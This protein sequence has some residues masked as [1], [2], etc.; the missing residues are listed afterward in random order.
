[1]SVE[2]LNILQCS[3]RVDQKNDQTPVMTR[4]G[5]RISNVFGTFKGLVARQRSRHRLAMLDDHMLEDIGLT[6]YD[7][8][9]ELRKSFWVK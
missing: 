2:T 6:R 9:R 5:K 1:M 3:E 4:L 8:E 7:V